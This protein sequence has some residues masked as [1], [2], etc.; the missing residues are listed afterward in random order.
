MMSPEERVEVE[1]LVY[2]HNRLLA[3]H[4][5]LQREAEELRRRCADL[6]ADRQRAR[7]A[8]IGAPQ[9]MAAS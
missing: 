7:T 5:Q 1:D 4:R 2:R 9:P 8:V 3:E 6:L